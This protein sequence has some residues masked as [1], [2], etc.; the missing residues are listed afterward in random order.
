MHFK[1]FFC[2]L[3]NAKERGTPPLMLKLYSISLGCPKNRV[4]T[5]RTLAALQAFGPICPVDDLE[6]ADCVFI[7]TCGFIAP[8]VEES[9]RTV[10]DAIGRIQA[11]SA[12][13]RP[14]LTVAGCL[15][16]RY[17]I[18]KLAPDLPEVDLFLDT[19]SLSAWG[20][21]LSEVLAQRGQVPAPA[22]EK[23]V[24]EEGARLLSTGP[25]YAWLKISDGCRH[26]CAFC[27]I[28][29]IRGR[30]VSAPAAAL[31]R[32]A[33]LLLE[34]GVQELVLVAQDLTAWGVDLKPKKSLPDLLDELLPLPGLTRLRLMYL[35][36]SGLSRELLAYLKTAGPPF[37]PYF[38]VPLQHAAAPV[39]KR[40]GRPF[41]GRPKEAVDRIRDVFPEAALRT[42]VIAGFPGERPEDVDEL[43]RFIQ[44]VRFHHLGVFAYQAEE[45]TSAA[46]L[47][48]QIPTA[49][50]ERRRDLL[51]ALQAE[52]SAELL[53]GYVGTR[54]QVLV[55]A[56][57]PEWLG[58]HI[59]RTWFQ[60]PESDG[61]TYVSGPGVAPG[62]V[63]EADITESSTYDLVGLTDAEE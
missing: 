13:K 62:K 51:M 53:E 1:C 9:V 17:S 28:P 14:L 36:P 2:A 16:G 10:V 47:P 8:A 29:A 45:G 57:H 27:T 43:A 5:E 24:P 58:L 49:E 19:R 38:D 55:D 41:A 46:G 20:N 18:E 50:K 22:P 61:I 30:L 44:E 39:L 59:G 15:I 3:P 37:V 42:S 11:L 7:N 26:A 12:K 40:M 4:D 63:V 34:Q 52:T 31:K 32:E 23:T 33:S 54:Q 48:D 60:A 25:S 35:Y 21:R 56:S 6:S